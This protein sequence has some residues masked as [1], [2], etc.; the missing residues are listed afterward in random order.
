MIR[1][2]VKNASNPPT[3]IP[4]TTPAAMVL[5]NMMA[6][7]L[8]CVL[9]RVSVKVANNDETQRI[10]NREAVLGSAGVHC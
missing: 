6:N 1:F 4:C 7:I 9:S 2:A 3:V 10:E 8:S 5:L